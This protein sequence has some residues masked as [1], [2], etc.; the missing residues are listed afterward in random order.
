MSSKGGSIP[1]AINIATQVDT[2][3]YNQT[4]LKL[5]TLP[6]SQSNTV[7]SY[8]SPIKRNIQAISGRPYSYWFF[9]QSY[10]EFGDANLFLKRVFV[11]AVNDSFVGLICPESDGFGSNPLCFT[12]Q[13]PAHSMSVHTV[14]V[15]T[16]NSSMFTDYRNIYRD[17]PDVTQG[18]IKPVRATNYVEIQYYYNKDSVSLFT[19][20]MQDYTY[21]PSRFP[22]STRSSYF[23][24]EYN[25]M[26]GK[27]IR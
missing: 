12:D 11:N 24:Y 20:S 18:H 26:L 2:E 9:P 15:R 4:I 16:L 8:L 13:Y 22:D 7:W 6:A 10:R 5:F 23:A 19:S 3:F 1:I 17:H 27:R 25:I 14:D 21:G